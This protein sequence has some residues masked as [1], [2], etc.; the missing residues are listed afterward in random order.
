MSCP[1]LCDPMEGTLV[2]LSFT[3]SQSLLRFM[4]IE[5]VMLSNHLILCRLLLLWPSIFP[6]SGSYPVSQLFASGCQR[7]G[8]S[9]IASVLPVNTQGQF[10]LGLTGLIS[11]LSKGLLQ[12]FPAPWFKSINSSVLILLSGPALTSLASSRSDYWQDPLLLFILSQNAQWCSLCFILWTPFS[13]AWLFDFHA[14]IYS[15]IYHIH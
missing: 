13:L 6:T 5:S 4:S 12:S 2:P 8:A 7:T 10:P 9:A 14:C 11:L 1:T 3:I 15:C